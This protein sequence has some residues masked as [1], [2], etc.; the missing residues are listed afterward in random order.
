MSIVCARSSKA[1]RC[2]S[3]LSAA[4]VTSSRPRMADPA[5]RRQ[6]LPGVGSLRGRLLWRLGGMLVIL[7]LLGSAATYF[8]AR[9]AADIAYD[10]TLLASAREIAD[11]LYERDGGL[12]AN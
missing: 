10:R 2:A 5:G 1:V 9:R 6:A 4:S 8:S 12:R 11:G 3:S 7:L